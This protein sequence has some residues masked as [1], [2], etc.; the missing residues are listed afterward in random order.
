MVGGGL[1]YLATWRAFGTEVTCLCVSVCSFVRFVAQGWFFRFVG[2]GLTLP[3]AWVVFALIFPS[4]SQPYYPGLRRALLGVEQVLEKQG[5]V[6]G[7]NPISDL[8]SQKVDARNSHLL[9]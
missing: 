7:R 3:S 4:T 8:P 6:I 5:S 1:H 9:P 2:I